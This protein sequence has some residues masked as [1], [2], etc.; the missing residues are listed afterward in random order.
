VASPYSMEEAFYLAAEM[1]G[2]VQ[3]F[4]TL[5]ILLTEKHLGES[6]MTV[7]IDPLKHI[8]QSLSC[9]GAVTRSI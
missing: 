5:G 1:L 2:L 9:I 6:R 8:G 3:E 7:D 4:Q